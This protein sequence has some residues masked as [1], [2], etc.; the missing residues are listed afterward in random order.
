MLCLRVICMPALSGK[1]NIDLPLLRQMILVAKWNNN[2][3]SKGGGRGEQEV[4]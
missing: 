3:I 1:A 2:I 4:P